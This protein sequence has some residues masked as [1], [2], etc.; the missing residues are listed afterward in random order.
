M[1]EAPTSA[2]TA[3]LSAFAPSQ[4][5]QRHVRALLPPFAAASTGFAFFGAVMVGFSR[6]EGAGKCQRAIVE[7]Y[8]NSEAA[9]AI[10]R[11]TEGKIGR[12][13]GTSRDMDPLDTQ[14]EP[15]N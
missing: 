8:A 2:D 13:T 10:R 5:P 11:V 15:L 14:L 7:A 9:A 6:C 4:K 12:A 1:A 3:S